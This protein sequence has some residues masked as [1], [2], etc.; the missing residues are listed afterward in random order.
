M[1]CVKDAFPALS[2][3]ISSTYETV[4]HVNNFFGMNISDTPLHVITS[5]FSA[6]AY[7]MVIAALLVPI[8]S[9]LTQV[10]N[11]KLS[12]AGDVQVAM[13]RAMRWHSR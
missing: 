4:S 12:A 9:Y 13:T 8:I 2:S 3:E 7:L 1:G 5:S 10:L 6:G 11:I